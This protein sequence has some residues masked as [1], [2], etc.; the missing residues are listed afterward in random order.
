[1]LQSHV[2]R[3]ISASSVWLSSVPGW[4]GRRQHRIGSE[5][6]AVNAVQRMNGL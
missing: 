1:M 5:S 2:N 3:Y 6:A 4:C